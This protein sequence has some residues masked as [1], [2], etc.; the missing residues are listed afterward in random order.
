[1]IGTVLTLTVIIVL[2]A[3]LALEEHLASSRKLRRLVTGERS[4]VGMRCMIGSPPDGFD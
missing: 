2:L 4:V 1:M 3:G